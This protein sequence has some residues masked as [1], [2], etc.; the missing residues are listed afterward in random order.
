MKLLIL[1][2]TQFVGRHLT[3]IALARNHEVTLFNR[4]R[5]SSASIANVEII[6][7]NRNHDLALLRGRRWDAVIDTCGYLP[8]S[9]CASAQALAACVN[10]YVFISSI[11]ACADFSVPGMDETAALATLT[12]EKLEAAN[13]IDQSGPISAIDYGSSYGGLKALCEQAVEEIMPS[14]ALILR[15]GLVV[16][17]GDYTD[18]FTYWVARVARGGEVLAPG[19][20]D[21][22]L[23]LI[24]VYDLAQWTIKMAEDKATG[25]YNAV[26]EPRRLTM[27]SILE[28]CKTVSKSNATFAWVSDDFL[29]ENQVAVWSDIPL[30]I[31]DSQQD[32]KGFMFI[33][34]NKAF[35]AGL[36]LRPIH[37]TIQDVL[38]WH[39]TNRTK[40][41]L[42]AGIGPDKER[43][44]LQLWHVLN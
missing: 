1:G 41:K 9:V 44:L 5:Y 15:P 37:E 2:G 29:L 39:Q 21:R 17:T 19:R 13:A 28:T 10:R 35:A 34:C 26:G 32:M 40:E 12:P 22:F 33:D 14:R 38:N 27:T 36:A 25:I 16:G 42:K 3:T 7:G 18:R 24:D 8:R 23:Q 20:P 11:S 30:W 43:E 6:H 4:G 31:P